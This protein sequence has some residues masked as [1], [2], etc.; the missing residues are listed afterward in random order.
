MTD[1]SYH[2][3]AGQRL[4]GYDIMP[5]HGAQHEVQGLSPPATICS[6]CPSCQKLVSQV[7]IRLYIQD[8]R[9]KTLGRSQCIKAGSGTTEAKMPESCFR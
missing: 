7:H 1:D 9:P 6:N 5:A 4:F 8:A 3:V 2:T